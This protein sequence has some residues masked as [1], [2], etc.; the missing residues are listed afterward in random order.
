MDQST[1]LIHWLAK[2]DIDTV[3]EWLHEVWGGSKSVPDNFY[4]PHL[5]KSIEILA[6]SGKG[7]GYYSQPDLDW[8][9][10]ALEIYHYV[11]D[12]SDIATKLYLEID[13]MYLKVTFILYYGSVEGDEMLDV[14]QFIPWFFKD[15]YISIEH[16]KDHLAHLQ[17]LDIE[18]ITFL[19]YIKRKLSVIRLLIDKGLLS[20]SEEL[21]DWLTIQD[22]LP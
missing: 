22:R 13:K 19:R 20:A 3:R 10:L 17:E 21:N 15:I 8:G 4:W 18:E 5:L 11:I 6:K 12:L 2:Q 14:S 16:I 7:P 1:E 9:R